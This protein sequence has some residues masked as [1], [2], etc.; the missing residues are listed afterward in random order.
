MPWT[1]A[2][3]KYDL[4]CRFARL[5]CHRAKASFGRRLLGGDRRPAS[6]GWAHP[7]P[8]GSRPQWRGWRTALTRTA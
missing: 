2:L 3:W 1:I 4:G 7:C 6:I 8:W 5:Q